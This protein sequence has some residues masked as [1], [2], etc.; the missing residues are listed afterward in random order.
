VKP[1]IDNGNKIYSDLFLD[2]YSY[3]ASH[4][5]LFV[6]WTFSRVYLIFY[7]VYIRGVFFGTFCRPFKLLPLLYRGYDLFKWDVNE[8]YWHS[9]Q[10]REVK[11][12]T[13]FLPFELFLSAYIQMAT[14]S[15]NIIRFPCVTHQDYTFRIYE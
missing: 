7:S 2:S 9:Q 13:I 8:P 4:S 10:E 11:T 6:I 5:I 14:T 15:P 12:D 3:T 1:F